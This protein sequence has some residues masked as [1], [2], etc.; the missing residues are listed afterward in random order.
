MTIEPIKTDETHG[1]YFGRDYIVTEYGAIHNDI[2]KTQQVTDLR[3]PQ[4]DR[5][6]LINY[7]I[8]QIYETNKI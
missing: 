2:I 7:L 3:Y 6:R 5:T 4:K 8:E 1:L